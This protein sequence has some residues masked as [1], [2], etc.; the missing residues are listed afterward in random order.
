MQRYAVIARLRPGTSEQA[1]HLIELGPPFDP[2][3]QGIDR[4]LVFLAPEA[5][6]FVFEGESPT[7]V[8]AALGD[9]DEQSAFGAWEPLLDGTPL[10]ARERYHW[11]RP[12]DRASTV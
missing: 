8:L 1:A 5:A 6:V 12:E 10:I 3:E 4:H 2:S 7:G 9:P 11:I